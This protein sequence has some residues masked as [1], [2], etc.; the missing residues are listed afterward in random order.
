MLTLVEAAG[1]CEAGGK[2]MVLGRLA[3]A[4]LPVPDGFILEPEEVGLIV[5]GNG[6]AL[7][8]RL[9]DWA[10][11]NA[12]FGLVVRSSAV[13]EDG[14]TASFAG[15]FT[16]LFTSADTAQVAGAVTAVHASLAGQGARAY[17]EKLGVS[18]PSTMAVLVQAAV[19]PASS[20]VLFTRWDDQGARIEAV[21]GLPALLVSGECR[22]DVFLASAAE[23]ATGAVQV[24]DKY[25][26]LLPPTAQEREVL[27]GE[28]VAWPG[29]GQAKVVCHLD[30]LIG[31]R[32]PRP[33]IHQPAVS[34][35]QRAD[36]L[37][38][39]TTVATVLDEAALD[40]EWACDGDGRTWLL[41]ARPD[42][43]TIVPARP[44]GELR[45]GHGT[46]MGEG[47]TLVVQGQAASPGQVT[48]PAQ[49]VG[50]LGVRGGPPREAGVLICGPA[51]PELVPA[52]LEAVGIA[53]SEAGLLCH[54]AI[55]AREL[56][57]P[58]ITDAGEALTSD[59]DGQQVT[60]DG[61]AGT[62]TRL[63]NSPLL[64]DT[65]AVSVS[66]RP[67]AP[68]SPVTQARG[69]QPTGLRVIARRPRMAMDAKPRF[70]LTLPLPGVDWNY[71]PEA[72]IAGGVAALL[73]PA[74]HRLIPKQDDRGPWREA[75]EGDAE[76]SALAGATWTPLPNGAWLA[77]LIT[78]P[79]PLPALW[80]GPS[81]GPY[82]TFPTFG[83]P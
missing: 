14:R 30:R 40:I 58:C 65:S 82:V 37:R 46:E 19:R 48:G 69:D 11:Q 27:P 59:W 79:T 53:C 52:L 24:A 17:A 49:V 78:P 62:L 61:D 22:P 3:R 12:P 25:V 64:G 6:R 32:P 42:T 31:V 68:G 44:P 74:E 5:T 54:T 47:R 77:W 28:W 76:R 55:V 39:A 33:L 35:V 60:L 15:Q 4:G 13:E 9:A 66:E 75:L 45:L 29:G 56:G 51:R 57:K 43:R 20:G 34:V 38:L 16:S 70:V 7:C 23:M 83:N 10:V 18:P 63:G 80:A 73:V 8:R 72:L 67:P 1:R 81:G 21:L 26:A 50:D 71:D 41:Q 36:L 2:A